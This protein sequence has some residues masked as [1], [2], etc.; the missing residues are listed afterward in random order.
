MS[1]K[2]KTVLPILSDG[3]KLMIEMA[4][5]AA[6]F[7]VGGGGGYAIINTVPAFLAGG[8]LG[9]IVEFGGRLIA[10]KVFRS[11]VDGELTVDDGED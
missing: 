3:T 6:I 7:V 4:I 11:E 2:N 5:A 1:T 10:L 8:T 9:V